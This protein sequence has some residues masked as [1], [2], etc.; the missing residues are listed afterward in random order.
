MKG[1]DFLIIGAQKCATTALFEH[2]RQHPKISMPLEK[3]V[4]FFTGR[5]CGEEAWI[6]Y[7]RQHLGE[8]DDR[9]WGKAT[10]QYMCDPSAA[11]RIHSLMPNTKL[12]AILRDP[13]E[14][15]FSHYQMGQ[16][17]ATE[18]RAFD[19]TIAHLLTPEASNRSR[20]LPVPGHANGYESEADFYV[21]W[22]EYGRVLDGYARLFGRDQLLV[23]YAEDLQ[24]DP[25]GTLDRLLRFIGL[26]AGFRPQ[27][28]GSIIHQGGG[29][30]RIPHGFRVWLRQ[31]NLLYSL[32]KRVPDAQQGRLRF[33]YE[34]WN[35]RKSAPAPVPAS[36][37]TLALL[38]RHF[39]EDLA[40]LDG[41]TSDR[42]PWSRR[43]LGGN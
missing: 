40:M 16:R 10:P 1:L 37:A 41:L 35:V 25:E 29:S 9:L 33:L 24:D 2:L 15:T 11:E 26:E 14:R 30:N 19:E 8:P 18:T 42:P 28:L 32:W 31:Q 39:T 38:R 7:S 5:D 3:E 21:A 13:V 36:D 23:L 20:T 43:Y 17:R 4:P 6:R 22:S 27:G 12:I 34:R